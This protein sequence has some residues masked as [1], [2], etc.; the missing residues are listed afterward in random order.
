MN[1]L[2]NQSC[3]RS[4]SARSPALLVQL[5]KMVFRVH[6]DVRVKWVRE[7]LQEGLDLQENLASKAFQ[8]LQET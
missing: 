8:E 1:C 4:L 7:V 6:L 3:H 2:S 5:V